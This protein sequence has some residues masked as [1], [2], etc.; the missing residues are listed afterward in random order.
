VNYA[1]DTSGIKWIPMDV[2]VSEFCPLNQIFI[3]DPRK[4][5]WDHILKEANET[6]TD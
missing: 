1:I 2:F 5:K 6:N 4:I 3:L